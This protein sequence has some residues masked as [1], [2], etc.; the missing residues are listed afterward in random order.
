MIS[1]RFL[2]AGWVAAVAFLIV[3]AALLG[4]SI[5]ILLAVCIVGMGYALVSGTRGFIRWASE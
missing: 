1:P 2:I 5:L 3:V 4:V